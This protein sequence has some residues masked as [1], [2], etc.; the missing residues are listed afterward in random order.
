MKPSRPLTPLRVTRLLGRLL[1]L[2][3][4]L[5]LF[6]ALAGP[7][8]ATATPPGESESA[9]RPNVLFIS[10]DDLRPEIGSYGV[11]RASSPHLDAFAETALVFTRAYCQQTLCNPSRTS[12]L[13]G[14][15]PATTGIWEQKGFFRDTVPNIVTLPQH[16]KAHGFTTSSIGKVFH[17][18]RLD[19][20]SWSEPE[21]LPDRTRIYALEENRAK[22]R[23]RTKATATESADVPDNGYR[24]GLA[25]DHAIK[26]LARLGRAEDSPFFLALGFFKPHLPF[27]A[28]KRYWDLFP[29]DEI[30]LP[31]DAKAPLGAVL[32]SIHESHEV[33]QYSDAPRTG[34]FS[35]DFS[36]RLLRGY[37]ASTAYV[38]AQVGRVLSAL[39]ELGLA[40]NT[41]VVIF[42]DHGF[43]L[44]DYGMWGKSGT[45][46]RAARVPLMVRVPEAFRPGEAQGDEAPG[47]PGASE[48]P[49]STGA[50]VE[51]VDLYPTLCDLAG[52][53]QPG[54]LEGTSFAPLLE[55]PTLPW[56]KAAFTYQPMG[57]IEAR[58]IRTK[59]WRYTSW[60]TTGKSPKTI[61][62]E[63][64]DH[65]TDPGETANLAAKPEQAQRAARL[66][67][68][69]SAGWRAAGPPVDR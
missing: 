39:D 14:A 37:L 7:V 47:D 65:T 63:L 64:Y 19:A 69:L 55:D 4:S 32:Y 68:I 56:K 27:A 26:T 45:F 67:S 53:P 46:E 51:L 23:P 50:L 59:R 9:E 11:G 52:L 6:A 25:A 24:D 13:T 3:A 33:R 43:Y 21:F 1:P 28:P 34:P 54:H 16:F 62:R 5:A 2:A 36:R 15:R 22:N 17:G 10:I 44:G 58:S 57:R 60:R 35:E 12:Y 8:V 30:E 42:G 41:I 66:E 20:K 18:N 31:K 49:G 40:D 38:D 29:E 61:A 48:R